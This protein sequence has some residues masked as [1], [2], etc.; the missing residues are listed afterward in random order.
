MDKFYDEL[1]ALLSEYRDSVPDFD[2]NAE[3]MPKLWQRIDA[4]R[5]VIFRMKRLTQVFVAG[6]AALCLLMAGV[7]VL[8]PASASND[9]ALRG[10][11]A[12]ILA[13]SHPIESLAALGIVRD[14]SELNGK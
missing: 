4:R 8:P 3:F 10:S 7:L 11:Y 5:S 9:P 13:E 12:D 6:A 1:N 14:A 2:A